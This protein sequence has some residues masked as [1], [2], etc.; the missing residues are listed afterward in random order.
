VVEENH[1]D[2]AF[3]H[4]LH[5]PFKQNEILVCYLPTFY[6][7]SATRW[8][9]FGQN[10]GSSMATADMLSSNDNDQQSIFK[11][12][13]KALAIYSKSLLIVGWVIS[14]QHNLAHQEILGYP[15]SVA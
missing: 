1:S 6:H 13:C 5:N 10:G 11:F 9:S 4:V 2:D 7:C 8:R 14:T 15:Q 12:M 3:Q